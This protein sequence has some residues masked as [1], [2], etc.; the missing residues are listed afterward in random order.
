MRRRRSYRR[1]RG[2]GLPYVYRNKVYLGKRSQKGSG[3][4][5]NLLAKI[6]VGA[7]NVVGVQMIRE[8]IELKEEEDIRKK[9]GS[10][11]FGDGF[12]YFYNLGKAWRKSMQ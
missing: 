7:G 6:L 11:I 4:L 10:G 9:G 8:N 12:K 2:R 5:T 1:K 3:I